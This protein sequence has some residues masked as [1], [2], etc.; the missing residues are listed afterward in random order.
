MKALTIILSLL[1]SL[2]AI[3]TNAQENEWGYVDSSL[4]EK[5]EKFNDRKLI[6]KTN[7][8]AIISGDVPILSSEFR[9]LS[10][11]VTGPKASVVVG[12]SYLGFGL[13][14]RQAIDGDSTSTI[15]SWDYKYNG[16]RVQGGFKYYLKNP[17]IRITDPDFNPAPQGVYLMPLVSYSKS[18]LSL[19]NGSN[20]NYQFVMFSVTANVGIQ[21]LLG[22]R[23]TMDP[24]IG[25]GYKDNQV[26]YDPGNGTS[27]ITNDTPTEGFIFA[28]PLKINM[29]FN[30]GF[31]L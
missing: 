21:F 29:G 26:F 14:M 31:R 10:E 6:I 2:G 28:S 15:S 27:Q 24:Y 11:W 5:A 7:P 22:K 9:V 1:L 30:L 20:E 4:V 8:L 18:K 16:F 3:N 13:I 25:L 19:R 12:A 17:N 23:I